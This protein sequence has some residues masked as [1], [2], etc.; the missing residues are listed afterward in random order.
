[1]WTLEALEALAERGERSL[2][3]CL[4][5]VEAGMTSWPEVRVDPA[6]ARRLGQGQHVDGGFRP[7]GSVA[8]FDLSGRALGL[9]EVDADGRL[10]PQ[11]LFS[12]AAVQP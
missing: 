7:P 5:P 8:M 2:D 4:L 3:A 1:M 10:C 12:W 11:R 9:G 6:Q